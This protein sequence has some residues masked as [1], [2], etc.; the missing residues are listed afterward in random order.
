MKITKTIRSLF[1]TCIV[2]ILPFILLTVTD[3]TTEDKPKNGLF[4]NVITV[5]DKQSPKINHVSAKQDPLEAKIQ[6]FDRQVQAK[7]NRIELA[8][9]TQSILKTV[10]TLAIVGLIAQPT[11]AYLLTAKQPTSTKT[12]QVTTPARAKINPK[13]RHL[14]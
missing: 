5:S 1:I 4:K 9:H 2:L 12:T 3:D 6:K 14:I 11:L 7:L 10:F 13:K 8:P